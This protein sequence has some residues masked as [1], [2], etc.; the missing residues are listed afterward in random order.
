MIWIKSPE[1]F[2]ADLQIPLSIFLAVLNSM[3]L[4]YTGLFLSHVTFA[5]LYLKTVLPHLK[6]AQICYCTKEI[7]WNIEICCFKFATDNEVERGEN[8]TGANIPLYTV[9]PR[10]FTQ[11]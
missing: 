9:R 4:L 2:F 5:F 11:Q 3:K 10:D 8:N 6:F 7:T 1:A